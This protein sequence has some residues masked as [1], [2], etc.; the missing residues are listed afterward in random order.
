M[1]FNRVLVC[2]HYCWILGAKVK[3][4]RALTEPLERYTFAIHASYYFLYIISLLNRYLLPFDFAGGTSSRAGHFRD[5]HRI[6][7]SIFR[8]HN[9]LVRMFSLSINSIR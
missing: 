8:A 5:D 9:S 6:Q 3:D 1:R 7:L 2:S 4:F